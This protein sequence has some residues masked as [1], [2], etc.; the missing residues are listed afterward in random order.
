MQNIFIFHGSNG[1][2][3]KHWYP[4]LEKKL[5]GKNTKVLIPEFPIGKNQYLNNW[6]K[7]L[8][9]YK[10]YLNNS[11]LIG[12]SLGVT[13]IINILNSRN[14][15]VKAVFLVSGFTGELSVDE[16]NIEDFSEKDFNW[17]KINNSCNKFYVVHSNNDPYVPLNKAQ[18]LSKYLKTKIIIVKNGGHFT[19]GSG[20]KKFD[21]LLEYVKKEL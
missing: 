5:E 12:H 1:N 15:N 4:W 2:P 20:Y 19:E 7:T 6:L 18:E 13:F 9:S 10:Q 11:I 8:D 14:I 16:P 21:L 17:Q 3:N